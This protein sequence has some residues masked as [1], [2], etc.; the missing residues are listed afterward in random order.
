MKEAIASI[1]DVGKEKQTIYKVLDELGVKFKKTNCKKCLNDLR[2]I[3]MEELGLIAS[4]ADESDFNGE[5]EYE[6]LKPVQYQWR[7]NLLNQRTPVAVIEAFLKA[8][9]H[10]GEYFRRKEKE[11]TN[12]TINTED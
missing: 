6:Y 12:N 8:N 11:D 2:Y 5:Y 9:P 10:G 4:A 3:A 7:D 1:K